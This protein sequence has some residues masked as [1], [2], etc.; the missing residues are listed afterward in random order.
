[1]I[2]Y[3]WSM[4]WRADLAHPALDALNAA[5]DELATDNWLTIP[6]GAWLPEPESRERNN[7]TSPGNRPTGPTT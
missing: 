5:I 3:P 7:R 4:I 2:L 1:M 6:E